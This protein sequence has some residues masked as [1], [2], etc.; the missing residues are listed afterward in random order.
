M[1]RAI[2]SIWLD[3]LLEDNVDVE[4]ELDVDVVL[5]VAWLAAVADFLGAIAI[6]LL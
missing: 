6:D 2:L 5:V 3:E 1:L 4:A